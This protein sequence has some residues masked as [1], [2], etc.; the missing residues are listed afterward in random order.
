MPTSGQILNNS[1]VLTGVTVPCTSATQP[2]SIAV[3]AIINAAAGDAVVSKDKSLVVSC[4]TACKATVDAL[5][6]GCLTQD[7]D[8][9]TPGFQQS[10][11]VHSDQSDC[12]DAYLIVVGPPGTPTET[13]HVALN[14]STSVP[15]M[16]TLAP[17]DT[18]LL[19]VP[20]KVVGVVEDTTNPNRG[21]ILSDP[22]SAIVTTDSPK[23]VILTPASAQI[24]LSDDTSPTT[25]GVQVTLTGTVSGLTVADKNAVEL[26][27][28]GTLTSKT[29]Q[30]PNGKFSIPMSFTTSGTHALLVKATDSCG[31][32][33]QKSKS[34]AVFVDQAGLAIVAPASDAVLRANDDLDSSTPDVLDTLITVAVTTE[35]TGTDLQVYCKP[36]PAQAYPATPTATLKYTDATVQTVDIPVS[37]AIAQFGQEI[38]CKVLDNAPNQAGS[39]PVSFVAA[40]PPPCLKV[41]TPAA[42]VI[43]TAPSVSYLLETSGLDG[44]TV[45]AYLITPGGV[46][47]DAV[48]L[49]QPA[50]N[51][52]AGTFAM[53]DAGAQVPDGTYTLNFQAMDKWG[54]VAGQSLCSD[55][56]RTVTMDTSPPTLVITLPVKATLTTLDDPDS[57][58]VLPGY[59]IDV[60]VTIT[61]TDSVCLTLD[62]VP[63]GCI[64]NIAPTAGTV[65]FHDVT[66]QP[67]IT[68]LAVT[69]S[70]I[71]GNTAA[72]P[73][74]YVTLNYDV[75]AVKWVSPVG[76]LTTAQD[77]LTFTVAVTDPDGGLPVVGASLQVLQ[78]TT[79]INATVTMIAPGLYT[80]TVSGLSAGST[81]V[82]VGA[83]V[84]AAPD[85]KGFS[86]Q[87]TVTFKNVKPTA[88]LVTPTDGQV[89]NAADLT[90]A[91]G[92]ADCVLPVTAAFTDLEDGSPVALTVTCGASVT[93]TTG[94]AKNG[95]I[96]LQ[97]VKL[98]DQNTCDLAIA[99]TDAA[100]QVA[101]S[102]VVHVTVDRVP[103]QFGVL[104][105]PTPFAGLTLLANNDLDSDPTNGMQVNWVQEV[106]GVQAGATVKCDVSDDLGKP[107]PGFSTTVPTTTSDTVFEPV[108]FGPITLPNG[109]NIKIVCS[110]SD[111]A[112]NV[113]QKTLI[114]QVL[115]DL[116][117]IHLLTP[118][119]NADACA[120]SADC[121]FGGICYQNVC[122]VPWNK[123]SDRKV[124]AQTSGVPDGAPTRLCSNSPAATGAPCA[125]A[126]YVT[127]A[128][129]TLQ[130]SSA[131]FDLNAVPDGTYR[132][133]AEA[134]FAAK[135]NWVD[136][137]NGGFVQGRERNLLIDTVPPTVAAITGPSAAGVAAGCLAQVEQTVSDGA[138][139]GGKFPFQITTVNED[140]SVSLLVNGVAAGSV[141]TSGQVGSMVVAIAAEGTATFE[142]VAVDLVGNVSDFQQWPPL[143]VDT[144]N[145]VGD[146]A[147][148]NKTPLIATDSLDV[149]VVSVA[150]DVEGEPVT[151][152]D[153]G[154]IKAVQSI[155]NGTALFDF[156]TFPVLT[157][158][159]HTLTAD[160]RDHC[161]NT[162]TAGTS[163]I[164]VVVDTQPPSVAIAAPSEGA[165]FT[166]NDD[167]APA[168]S[169]YQVS[170]TFSTNG[171]STWSVELGTDC[172]A[173]SQNC[174]AFQVVSSGAISNPGGAEAPVLVTV[175]FG[176]TVHY[177][178]RVTVA[179]ASGNT[180]IAAKGFDV[181]LSGCLVKLTGLPGTGQFNTQNCPTPGQNC[182][183]VTVPLTVSYVG[184]CGAATSVQ[185]YKGGVAVASAAPVGQAAAFDVTIVDGDSTDI[186]AVVLQNLTPTGSSGKLGVAA[187]LTNPTIAFAAG[188]VLG[189]P[190]VSGTTALQGKDQDVSASSPDHQV[191]LQLALTDAH[192]VGGKL[193]ALDRTAGG[194]T[195][196]LANGSVAAPIALTTAPQTVDVQ[197]ASLL[198]DQLNTITA[199][200]QDSFG[201]TTTATLAV[202]VDWQAPAAVTLNALTAANVNPRRPAA[203]LTFDAV[204]DNGITGQATSYIVRYAK[205]A[206]NTQA[207]FDAACDTSKLPG[208]VA[209]V[210][211]AAG[212]AQSVTVSGPDVRSPADPCK[213]APFSDDP[214]LKSSYYFAVVAVDAAGNK[215]A[216]SNYAATDK[217]RLNFMRITNSGGAGSTYDLLAYRAR[218][219]GVGD[220]NGD[221]FGD[222]GIG[223]GAT[224]P[225]CIVYGRAGTADI[226]L[227]TEP[228]SGLQ[229]LANSGGLGGVVG[230]PADVNGDGISDLI[231]GNKTGSGIP[232]EVRV[233]LGNA[234][235][236]LSA[237][238]A[239]IITGIVN[240]SAAGAGPA[241]LQTV[242]NFNG[243][244]SASGKP[245]MD[246]AVRSAKDLNYAQSETVYLI[247]GSAGWS[248]ASPLTIDV[249]NTLDRS[250]NNVVRLRLSDGTQVSA[251][252]G[253]NFHGGNVL[254]ENGGVGQQYDEL[255][256]S[257]QAAAQQ[258]Y[259]IRGR[260]LSGA[261][262]M[263]MTVATTGLQP[264]DAD[265]VR[266]YPAG[267]GAQSFAAYFDL[268]EFDGLPG[269]DL[270]MQHQ[271]GSVADHPG[272]YWARGSTIQTKYVAP[273]L[274]TLSLAV[275]GAVAG[276]TDLFTTVAGY[277]S[278]TYVWAPQNIGNFF[279]NPA[280]GL[281]T[282]VMYARPPFTGATG[283]GQQVILRMALPRAETSGEVGFVYEDVVISDP[284]VKTNSAFGYNVTAASGIGFAP[285]G[286]FN[287]DGF[288]DLVIGSADGAG[289]VKGS[290]LIVY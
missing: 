59:Q 193:T 155:L 277:L 135:S 264:N 224:A 71:N 82:Q 273:P 217:L 10:F 14:G 218:V 144:L 175:P 152:R 132:V 70:D 234:G 195:A 171:A 122:T 104:K 9:T 139:P 260:Q 162:A 83:F 231:I 290:T 47:L 98:L 91:L 58:P 63:F 1:A 232:R 148:P 254:L 55:V 258:V 37:L 229:C 233:Y 121:Q 65:V 250:N 255:V 110:V 262:D 136:S 87:I 168:Q 276:F 23:I 116:P 174:N 172:D 42:S 275:S 125:T 28:D 207:D 48:D 235:A 169:G 248:N 288:V 154:V 25:P 33:G 88:T 271:T 29:T 223:G 196:P 38:E 226:D 53:F 238:P 41:I 282:D 240:T 49:G 99:V 165:L 249:T 30:A 6:Q 57:D 287:K 95:A 64:K 68:A 187:D 5:P 118:Y 31:L 212:T 12:T 128:Q 94:T 147:N 269:L 54:N 173:G 167:A 266:I 158:G 211:G 180:A 96:T 204:G 100:G 185:L 209:L 150:N 191:H 24:K 113:A 80:F 289:G 86:G 60:E 268:V 117:L 2:I 16:A 279:D 164:V 283:G 228:A 247:P 206:I 129:S 202:T 146:F 66:L 210:P 188:T 163:P 39:A 123:S 79:D 73:P 237:T 156:A 222:V 201:N 89:I 109:Y 21:S 36:K 160:L 253:Q 52:L 131:T 178:L 149:A 219:F 45:Q 17:D 190:T 101:T 236:Q 26:Y 151:L 50:T 107:V 230:G 44:Q 15:V 141:T 32:S 106:A 22:V 19:G 227:A 74:T 114:A 61:D 179:D 35:T 145:P 127:I 243:D 103:P 112:G 257:Q 199:T 20:V 272:F 245:V 77:S 203:T 270:V 90:C 177:K 76:S 108:G 111:S 142:T 102:P 72:P 67:G 184:P 285:V 40:L 46:P 246:I 252:F 286:D 181:L 267:T 56:T 105:A 261:L 11:V 92:Q 186:E 284:F 93:T 124:V 97:N 51:H 143:L 119:S 242:G 194:T 259:V 120:T 153:L 81:T 78:N 137:Q 274:N 3:R 138:L 62:G 216:I 170:L 134:F 182:A 18:G 280:A 43:V 85:K 157:D 225:F 251:L 13:V 200:A 176:N 256:V 215:G 278:W 221:G 208:F 189:S 140:A 130:K 8:P 126:G 161:G 239:V 115:A 197:Y 244:L 213:F 166:D 4:G 263:M 192:L 159:S 205:T 69:G 220:L 241:R 198:P 75:P 27:I 133:I 281:H 214:S 84:A 183:S 7:Q 265:T 34:L